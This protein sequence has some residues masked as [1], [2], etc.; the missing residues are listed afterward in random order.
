MVRNFFSSE[1]LN[2]L[3]TE[4]TK[5][6]QDAYYSPKK[7]CNVYLS[8]GDDYYPTDHPRNMFMPRTNGFVRADTV[9]DDTAARR[10]YYWGPLKQ[11]LADCLGKPE[12]FIYEG[13]ISNMIVNVG[14][15]GRQFN[16]HFDTNEFTITLLLKPA[17][18]GGHFEY[19]LY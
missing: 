12:L 17:A 13:P 8:D 4:A 9:A 7:E 2:S 14:K 5:R 15:K 16:W 3:Q 19:V 1:G 18:S 10:L 11:F 6:K